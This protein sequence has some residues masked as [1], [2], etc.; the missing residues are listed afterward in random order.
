MKRR[1][2]HATCL[3]GLALETRLL[4]GKRLPAPGHDVPHGR[5]YT[6]KLTSGAFFLSQP[7]YH[8]SRKIRAARFCPKASSGLPKAR[9]ATLCFVTR[10]PKKRSAATISGLLATPVARSWAGLIILAPK[11]RAK[12]RNQSELPTGCPLCRIAKPTWVGSPLGSKTV[13][14]FIAARDR[15]STRLNSSHEWISYAVFC[16]KKKNRV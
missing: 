1:K 14:F 10:S 2:S 9:L 11:A 6:L 3:F 13:S 7:K 5:A 12:G 16:L 8:D 4:H 15:K